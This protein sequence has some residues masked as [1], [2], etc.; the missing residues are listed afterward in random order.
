M[1]RAVSFLG[2]DS[3]CVRGL[4]CILLHVH[5][6]DAVVNQEL[7]S[8]KSSGNCVTLSSLGS[9]Y[10]PWFPSGGCGRVL[11]GSC[12]PDLA[13]HMPAESK[14]SRRLNWRTPQMSVA[15]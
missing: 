14:H 1:S 6:S 13:M 5:A 4:S 11:S 2:L 12:C 3:S 10:G 7:D 15:S 8:R 9:R